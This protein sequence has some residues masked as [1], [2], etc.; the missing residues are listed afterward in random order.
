MRVEDLPTNILLIR[1]LEG[2]K[3]QAR[4]AI[5]QGRR[6]DGL[7]SPVSPQAD[8]SAVAV[9]A[10]QQQQRQAA[11]GNRPHVKALFNYEARDPG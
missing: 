9:F 10:R 8:T 3:T 1:L 4:T 11:A 7:G 6:R 2:I 5:L